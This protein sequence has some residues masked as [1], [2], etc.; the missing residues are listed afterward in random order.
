MNP[1]SRSSAARCRFSFEAGTSTFALRA[2][3]ALRIRVRKSAIGSVMIVPL[4]A[5][6]DH[7]GDVAVQRQLAEADPAKLELAD[8]GARTAA[9]R[10]A[11]AVADRSQMSV[12]HLGEFLSL[13][14][15]L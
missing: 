14:D 5:R 6:L 13:V 12:H 15:R 10:A 1:S 11:V 3:I 2:M 4:P 9:V 7:A 8:E